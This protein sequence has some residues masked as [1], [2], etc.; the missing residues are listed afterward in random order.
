MPEEVSTKYFVLIFLEEYES[1]RT[2][3]LEWSQGK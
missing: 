3:K 2:L 1:V